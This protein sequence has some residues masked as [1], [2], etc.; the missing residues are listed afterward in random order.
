MSC[1]SV[2]PVISKRLVTVSTV[3]AFEWYT[4]WIPAAAITRIQS[5]LKSKGVSGN[6]AVQVAIQT[7]SIRPDDPDSPSVVGSVLSGA[8][9]LSSSVADVTAPFSGKYFVRFGVAYGLT[10]GTLAQ[11]DV[12]LLLAYD[13]CGS[14]VGSQVL[15]F[16]TSSNTDAFIPITTWIPSLSTEKVRAVVV[17]TGSTSLQWKLSYR[18]AATSV[19]APNGWQ[20]NLEVSYHGLGS[21]NTGDLSPSLGSDMWIQFGIQYCSS[22]G[23]AMAFGNLTTTVSVRKS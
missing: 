6:I 10:G 18:T 7:A 1:N 16:A 21:V 15:A 2:T 5:V 20:S 13:M 9:E 4:D 14:V 22:S 8:G 12:S 3:Q 11:G 19:E 23:G 17:A